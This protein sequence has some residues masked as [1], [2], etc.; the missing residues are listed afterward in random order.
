MAELLAVGDKVPGFVGQNANEESLSLAGFEGKWLVLY[1]YPKAHTSGCTREGLAFN[2]LLEDFRALNAEVVGVST[3]KPGTLAKFRD[4]HDFE[5]QL[6]SDQD[7]EIS[8]VCGTLKDHGKSTNRV[9]YII[10]PD[11]VVGAVWKSVKVDG[12]A[13]K[14]L[15]RLSDLSG[16]GVD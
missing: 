7:K 16:A 1:F 15:A 3:D 12:H 13:E 5:F 9:T 4:K 2:S 8:T 11:G 10:D 6:L 14:V